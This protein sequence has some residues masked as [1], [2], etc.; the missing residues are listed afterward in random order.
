MRC[1]REPSRLTS[2]LEVSRG[3]GTLLSEHGLRDLPC[4]SPYKPIDLDHV[5]EVRVCGQPE[6]VT[7]H[8]HQREDVRC[9]VVVALKSIES[10]FREVHL[11]R[12]ITV[13]G[14][15]GLTDDRH[16]SISLIEE[17]AVRLSEAD[18]WNVRYVADAFVVR[19]ERATQRFERIGRVVRVERRRVTGRDDNGREE[20]DIRGLPE[21]AQS[22]HARWRGADDLAC[23][24]GALCLGLLGAGVPL[25]Q[26][27]VDDQFRWQTG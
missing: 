25:Q 26:R 19:A 16:D 15:V 24:H 4:R 23:C 20:D 22:R 10:R 1:Y 7:A 12:D 21:V 14:A 3:W 9:G 2:S 6:L 11:I 27:W 17:R 13:L 18:L 5:L 8:L